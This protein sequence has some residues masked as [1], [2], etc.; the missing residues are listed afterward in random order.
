M[1]LGGISAGIWL[2][3]VRSESK[4]MAGRVNAPPPA[5]PAL[6]QLAENGRKL[7]EL[8]TVEQQARADLQEVRDTLA[9]TM[10]LTPAQAHDAHSAVNAAQV[11]SDLAPTALDVAAS[12]IRSAQ[13]AARLHPASVGSHTMVSGQLSARAA[14]EAAQTTVAATCAAVE[15]ARAAADPAEAYTAPRAAAA[16]FQAAQT[17]VDAARAAVDAAKASQSALDA[18]LQPAAT[19]SVSSTVRSPRLQ[20]AAFAARGGAPGG[21]T[22]RVGHRQPPCDG[23]APWNRISL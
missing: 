23:D 8:R 4:T 5:S 9:S 7:V 3:Y 19:G 22:E 12:A 14:A 6:T 20:R 11:A 10:T 18:T 13:T 15:A 21:R 2:A 17:A 1:L 16:G